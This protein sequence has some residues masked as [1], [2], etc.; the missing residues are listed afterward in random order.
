[1]TQS[2]ANLT[3]SGV[4]ATESPLN[5]LAALIRSRTPLIAVESNERNPK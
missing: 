2:I 3:R 1:M 5:D 4:L